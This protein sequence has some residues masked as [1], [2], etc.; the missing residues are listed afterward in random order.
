M[1]SESLPC[2]DFLQSTKLL[3]LWRKSDD[4]VR[5][6]L[7]TELPTVSFQNKVDYSNK[8]S[9]FID[10]MLRN[11]EKRTSEITDCIKFTSVKL[12][13]LRSSSETSN[14][15]DNKELEREIRNKQLLLRQFQTEL[16]EE[17]V[18]QTSA[19]KVIYERCREHFRHPIFDKFKHYD[20]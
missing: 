11:H 18:I 1:S 12:N 2:D 9:A 8:C 19:M 7:N 15:V 10:R 13:A 5:H 16:L 4:R 14:N 3:N 6:E 20:L 17:K